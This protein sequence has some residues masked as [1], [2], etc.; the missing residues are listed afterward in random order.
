MARTPRLPAYTLHK[1]TGQARVYIDGKSVYLGEYGSEKSRIAYGEVISRHSAGLP[2]DP[3]AKGKPSNGLDADTGPTIAELLLGYRHMPVPAETPPTRQPAV[4]LWY[5]R[6]RAAIRNRRS[7]EA[8]DSGR[9]R[10]RNTP[11]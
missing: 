3:L 2:I 4:L 5:R 8:P 7:A 6:S 11:A 1:S 10:R 9:N